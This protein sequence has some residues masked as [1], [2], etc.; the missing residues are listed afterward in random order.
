M[1]HLNATESVLLIS[2]P[3]GHCLPSCLLKTLLKEGNFWTRN[4][5]WPQVICKKSS[6]LFTGTEVLKT[7]SWTFQLGTRTPPCHLKGK[8][9]YSPNFEGCLLFPSC[10]IKYWKYRIKCNML[11]KQ[12]AEWKSHGISHKK[13]TGK[14]AGRKTP[15]EEELNLF[16]LK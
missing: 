10:V 12:D 5:S 16:L 7:E 14:N 8:K 15:A 9:F 4:Q 13:S 3:S 11:Q 1:S 2:A 6:P